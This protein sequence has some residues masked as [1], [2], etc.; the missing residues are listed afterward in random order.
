[1]PLPPLTPEQRAEALERAARAPKERAEIRRG[2]K[3]GAMSL[4]D[5]INRGATDDVIGKMQ[6]SELLACLPGVDKAGAAQIMEQLGIAES[7]RVRSL[8]RSQREALTG[9][10]PPVP[11]P[12]A[13]PSNRP[14]PPWPRESMTTDP[15]MIRV[16]DLVVKADYGQIYIFSVAGE[17]EDEGFNVDEG[18]LILALDD[19]TQSGRFVGVQ[20]GF[21]DLLTPGQWNWRTPLRLEIWSAEPADDRG[22]WDHEVDADFD[23]PDGRINF[24]PSGTAT[25]DASADVPAGR[26]RARISGRGF[27]EV[28]RAGAEGDDSYRMRLWPRSRREDPALRKRWPGW[29]KYR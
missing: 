29:D 27:T 2:L 15:E 3:L 18:H 25:L 24:M 13:T 23:V 8:S 20:P 6:V 4:P 9:E 5:V 11:P 12:L 7:R 17:E 16:Q 22:D 14:P 10:L 26:Y 1:M 19:A 28:G 21:I